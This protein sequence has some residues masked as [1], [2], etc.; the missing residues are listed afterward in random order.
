MTG[1][2]QVTLRPSR[3]LITF[4]YAHQ[5]DEQFSALAVSSRE[6]LTVERSVKGF[7]ANTFF[8][9]VTIEALYRVA[10]VV[11]KA[12]GDIDR[13]M[14]YDQFVDT[15]DVSPQDPTKRGDDKTD[16][17]DGPEVDPTTRTA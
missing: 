4:G 17:D 1:A 16:E 8:T 11:L 14:P 2:G 9:N 15:Y 5:D 10:F 13:A 7:S 6:M 3:S 12:R